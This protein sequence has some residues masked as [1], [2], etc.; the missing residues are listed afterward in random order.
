METL[1]DLL[2]GAS[3]QRLEGA[4]HAASLR[5]QVLSNN[6][7]NVDVPNYKRSDVLF[8]DLLS[9]AMGA[10]KL[11]GKRTHERH[12]PIGSSSGIPS[13]KVVTDDTSVFN[14]NRNNVDID[15]E[16]SLLA[17]NQLLHNFYIQQVNHEVR[18]LRIGMEGRG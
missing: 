16:M 1:M 10:G 4:L 3:F 2:G 6:I 11:T 15:K 5:Q 9:Q 17:Q 8:E 12:I 18:M 7:A 13:A 14:N